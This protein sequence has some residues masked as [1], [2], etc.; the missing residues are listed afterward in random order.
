MLREKVA[1]MRSE[2]K[3]VQQVQ[4]IG[5]PMGKGEATK[6]EVRKDL[7]RDL[8]AREHQR[9]Q[10]AQSA[11]QC[12]EEAERETQKRAEMAQQLAK[13]V[14]RQEKAGGDVETIQ[15]TADLER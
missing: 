1:Q 10:A 8:H 6:A 4:E 14:A 12:I 15:R 7:L 11:Q 5:I 3:V 13:V 2:P 9:E